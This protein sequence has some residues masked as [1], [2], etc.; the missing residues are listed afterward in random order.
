[1]DLE[2][3]AADA[4]ALAEAFRQQ[5]KHFDH[6][7]VQSL[8]DAQA[9]RAG[10]LQTLADVREQIGES[11]LFVLTLSGHGLMNNLGEYYFAPHDFDP[12]GTVSASGLSWYDL[13]QE[14]KQAPGAVLVILDTCHSGSAIASGTRGALLGAMDRSIDRAVR[15]LSAAGVEGSIVLASSLSGQLS[16]ERPDWG[17]GALT[18]AILESL[19]GTALVQEGVGTSPLPSPGPEGMLSIEAIRNYAVGRVN[20]ISNGQ[21]RVISRNTIDLLSVGLGVVPAQR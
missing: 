13:E 6:V 19:S 8:T 5:S 18:L 4:T 9:T 3:G 1:M 10:I 12:E 11:S 7:V 15:Q 17:H 16:Q 20:A 14:F 21:Q 2:Y